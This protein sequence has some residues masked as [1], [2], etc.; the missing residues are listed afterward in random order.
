MGPHRCPARCPSFSPRPAPR[1]R[2]GSRRSLR[3]SPLRSGDGSGR[4]EKGGRMGLHLRA[5]DAPRHRWALVLAAVAVMAA[6][7]ATVAL[8][9]GRGGSTGPSAEGGAVAAPLQLR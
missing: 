6:V 1:V 3:L 5:P 7:G 8:T 9:H 2:A 4:P